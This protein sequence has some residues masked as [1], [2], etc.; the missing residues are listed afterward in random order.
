MGSKVQSDGSFAGRGGR[1]EGVSCDVVGEVVG[2][3]SPE[4]AKLALQVSAPKPV[5]FHAHGLCLAVNYCFVGCSGSGGVVAL[6]M[7][8]GLGPSHFGKQLAE[9]DHLFGAD[10][11]AC[12]I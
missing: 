5:E 2:T 3:R 8:P 10:V 11:K 4:V 9:W 7:R 1:L 6:D 12:K